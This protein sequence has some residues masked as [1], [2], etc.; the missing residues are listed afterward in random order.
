MYLHRILLLIVLTAVASPAYSETVSIGAF[1]QGSL[2]GWEEQEF[3]NKTEY[4][5]VMEDGRRVLQ[6]KS[7]SAASG[8]FK[9]IRI[10]LE[11]TP[12]LHWSWKVGNTL[13]SL[14]ETTRQGDDY[15]ARIYVVASGGLLF[16][17]TLAITY[18]W[19]S[20]QARGKDWPNAFTT[21][22]QMLAVQSGDERLGQWIEERH[23]V[24][25]DFRRM[26]G[27]DVRYIDAIAVMTDTDNAG[28]QATA[29]YGDIYFAAD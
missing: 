9:E 17:D 24:R 22:A 12:Y 8:L 25:A 18:V 20:R 13:G 15:P 21:R 26:F 19:A 14:D 28:G 6:A 27:Q 23:N 4:R 29:Y 7:Q 2:E 10:D 16:W 3:A 1:S 5:L 11:R